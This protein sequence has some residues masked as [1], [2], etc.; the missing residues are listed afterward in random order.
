M[1]IFNVNKFVKSATSSLTS[2]LASSVESKILNLESSSG[3]LGTVSK[4]AG[5]VGLTDSIFGQITSAA[6]GADSLVSS[7]FSSLF[8]GSGSVA[9][10]H[11]DAHAD[12]H[13]SP[14]TQHGSESSAA[15]KFPLDLGRFQ[16]RLQ[17]MEYSRPNPVNP[18]KTT[19][20][21]AIFLP[22]PQ[23]LKDDNGIEY[24]TKSLG[25]IGTVADGIQDAAKK[26]GKI[27]AT[28]GANMAKAAG[29]VAALKA[30]AMLPKIGD[31]VATITGQTLGVTL[32]PGL[33]VAFQGPQLRTFSMSWQFA[34][35]SAAESKALTKIIEQLKQRSLASMTYQG[36]TALLSYPNMVQLE[37]VP[38]I[39][40]YKK[41]MITGISVDYASD[42]ILTFFADTELPV[43][44]SLQ[45]DFQE[46]EYF[47]AQDFGATNPGISD[48]ALQNA[49]SVGDLI[50]SEGTKL[51]GDATSAISSA[52]SPNPQGG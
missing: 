31:E 25:L 2:K 26:D 1:G 34:P 4:I 11:V 8:G 47:T 36:N 40:P 52:I 35:H 18:P 50:K 28:A 13:A 5:E 33:S 12:P 10:N 45:L 38:N 46:I 43:F 6:S 9:D 24:N 29:G 20:T 30:A 37:L 19:N 17:F 39:I 22:L 44:I 42:G 3:I 51:L 23:Q 7:T 41:A 49:G 14:L 48:S 32:N 15:M 21:Q 27:D 16:T